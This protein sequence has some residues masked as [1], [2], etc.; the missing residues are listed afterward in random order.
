MILRSIDDL[1]YLALQ[2][3]TGRQKNEAQGFTRNPGLETTEALERV[4]YLSSGKSGEAGVSLEF[5][6]QGINDH[7]RLSRRGDDFEDF[8]RTDPCV[9][10]L[11]EIV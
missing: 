4:I 1:T 2:L 8:L 11:S 7:T 9:M 6:S 3:T 5:K 10:K